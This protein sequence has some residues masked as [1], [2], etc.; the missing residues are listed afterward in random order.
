GDHLRYEIYTKNASGPSGSCDLEMSGGSLRDSG[1]ND[2]NG[3]SGH[4][5]T[6]I[7]SYAYNKWY[8]RDFDLS[9]RA[10]NTICSFEAA[11]DGS[12]VS[13]SEFYLRNVRIVNNGVVK[14]NAFDPNT[15][16]LPTESCGPG[17]NGY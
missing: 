12:T 10:G 14:L 15:W 9:G 11:H 17:N 6:N 4:P 1:I 5:A 3:Q 13:P 2:Q 16:T 7:S 8:S